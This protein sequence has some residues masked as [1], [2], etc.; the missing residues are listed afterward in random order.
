MGPSRR[1]PAAQQ[2]AAISLS[3]VALDGADFPEAGGD[4]RDR[5]GTRSQG[6][7]HRRLD[8]LRR[9]GDDAQLDFPVVCFQV[10]KA[11]DSK[12]FSGRG[13]D[14]HN[15]ADE[16]TGNQVGQDLVAHLAG[17]TRSADHG[18]GF[19]RQ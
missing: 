2:A 4:H 3:R 8:C 14:R 17:R 5:S 19:W 12:H 10:R 16:A 1:T 18:D 11:L 15:R 13:I 9:Y 6:L 7:P